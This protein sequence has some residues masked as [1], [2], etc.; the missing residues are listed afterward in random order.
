MKRSRRILAGI[1][2]VSITATLFTSCVK[3]TKNQV[4]IETDANGNKKEVYELKG[5]TITSL[6]DVLIAEVNGYFAEEGIK[7]KDI[8]TIKTQDAVPALLKNDIN[9]T[10]MHPDKLALARLAGSKVIAIAP[11]MIDDLK[12]PHLRYFVKEGSS[13]KTPQD[14][15]GKKIG[16]PFTGSCPDGI[17]LDWLN[18]NGIPKEKV[19]FVILN[20]LQ[21]EQ[22]LKQ[23][24]VDVTAHHPSS[25]PGV[26]NHGGVKELIN[27]WD[28]VKNP[29]GG[30]SFSITVS[31]KWAKE[32]PEVA[33]G[34][35]RAIVK[36]HDYIN[37][38]REES[39]KKAAEYLKMDIK[40]ITAFQYDT[41]KIITDERVTPWFER[42]IR[43]GDLKP[44]QIKESEIYT[45]EYNPYYKK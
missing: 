25:Y 22:S 28:I 11:G 19:E 35:V 44:G 34:L 23:G 18:Q 2:A 42:M 38:H 39:Y 43:L 5:A 1:L 13:I 3:S 24:Q 20:E 16:V 26:L 45:N 29:N 9:F 17:L 37:D 7:Y 10:L 41:Q 8:G 36:A 4:K 40:D 33:K 30:T 21:E 12:I 15:I 32:N 14:L 31:E 27:T 6:T